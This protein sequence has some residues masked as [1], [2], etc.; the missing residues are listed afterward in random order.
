MP[1]GSK[2]KGLLG[3]LQQVV[4]R[5]KQMNNA[6]TSD[7]DAPKTSDATFCTPAPPRAISLRSL[8]DQ[9]SQY[10]LQGVSEVGSWLSSL[11]AHLNLIFFRIFAL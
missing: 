11:V 9:M 8:R 2:R 3:T 10:N 6:E 7:N 4:Q 1:E 5:M